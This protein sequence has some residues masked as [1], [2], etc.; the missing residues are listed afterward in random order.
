MWVN[1]ILFLFKNKKTCLGEQGMTTKE[2]MGW[3]GCA[4]I[5]IIWGSYELRP[6]DL[7][8]SSHVTSIFLLY[9]T[10][11]QIGR[12]YPTLSNSMVIF[13][14]KINNDLLNFRIYWPYP[15]NFRIVP[16]FIIFLNKN[17]LKIQNLYSKSFTFLYNIFIEDSI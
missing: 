12:K 6:H 10:L 2:H 11:V 8:K 1:F 5:H 9:Q 16:H 14:D 15:R 3:K 4:H 13:F 17:L 7:M